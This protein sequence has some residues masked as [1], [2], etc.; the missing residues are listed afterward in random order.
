M[1]LQNVRSSRSSPKWGKASASV[2]RREI[3]KSRNDDRLV[4]TAHWLY[5]SLRRLGRDKEA[6]EVLVPI[7]RDMTV[8]E[9][10][11]AKG[12][13]SEILAP[14]LQKKGH[15]VAAMSLPE[16]AGDEEAQSS[17]QKTLDA[18]RTKFAKDPDHYESAQVVE[19]EPAAPVP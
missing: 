4:S 14:Y 11:P 2:Y 17:A 1:P 3:A 16:R 15:Y 5:M 13:Y 9:I 12:W 7:R 19:F 6:A 18:R 10:W 8:I